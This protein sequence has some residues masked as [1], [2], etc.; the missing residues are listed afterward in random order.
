VS[1]FVF[2]AKYS[3]QVK[4]DDMGRKKRNAWRILVGKLEKTTR[5]A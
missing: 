1:Y 5:K 4:E 3:D 2:F